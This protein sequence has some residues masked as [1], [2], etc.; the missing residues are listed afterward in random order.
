MRSKREKVKN[1]FMVLSCER[2]MER[3]FTKMG[4]II[5]KESYMGKSGVQFRTY[6]YDF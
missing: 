3:P 6:M 1:G 4:N 5:G 2:R